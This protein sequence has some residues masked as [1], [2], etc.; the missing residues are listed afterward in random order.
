M[1]QKKLPLF[2]QVREMDRA[3]L[4]SRA[5]GSLFCKAVQLAPELDQLVGKATQSAQSSE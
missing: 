3:P 1:C 4:G 2:Q 5:G